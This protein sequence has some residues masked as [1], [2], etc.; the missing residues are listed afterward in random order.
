MT[1]KKFWILNATVAIVVLLLGAEIYL[2]GQVRLN[3]QNIALTQRTI[4]EGPGYHARWEKLALRT[5]QLSQ[6]DPA[7]KEVLQ[8]QQI[9]VT[10]KPGSNVPASAPPKAV[11]PDSGPKPSAKKQS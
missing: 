6:Q 1:K 9:Q 8:R 2:S 7:L 3:Q 4:A 11:G 10:P 5:Y